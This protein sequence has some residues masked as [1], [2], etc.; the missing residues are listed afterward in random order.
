MNKLGG[1]AEAA[2]LAG[3]AGQHPAGQVSGAPAT[4]RAADTGVR[5]TDF[6]QSLDRGLAVI[7]CFSSEHPSLTLSEVARRV[8]EGQAHSALMHAGRQRRDA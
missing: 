7:R 8:A 6:V 4:R 2:G 1:A 5:R 3:E